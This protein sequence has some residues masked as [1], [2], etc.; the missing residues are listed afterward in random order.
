M[1]ILPVHDDLENV[2]K[3]P[4]R[5]VRHLEPPPDGRIAL[6]QRDLELVDRA[7]PLGEMPFWFVR[8]VQIE[9]VQEDFQLVEDGS[10][11]LL[12]RGP[13]VKDGQIDLAGEFV[14]IVPGEPEGPSPFDSSVQWRSDSR[15]LSVSLTP[16]WSSP[17]SDLVGSGSTRGLGPTR[18]ST[19]RSRKP[20]VAG[21]SVT[22]GSSS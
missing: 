1:A 19:N 15:C 9:S 20:I 13:S 10:E 18:D 5:E 17:S 3:L 4:E 2:V 6:F 22:S 16:Y 11:P 8:F 12:V 7:G 14:E 21:L